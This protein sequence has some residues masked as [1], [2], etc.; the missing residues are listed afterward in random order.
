MY[1]IHVCSIVILQK[2][3]HAHVQCDAFDA[4]EKQ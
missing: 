4:G 2:Y 1:Y 3:S